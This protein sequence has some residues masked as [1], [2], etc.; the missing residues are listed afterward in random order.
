MVN[1]QSRFSA[2]FHRSCQ[3]FLVSVST[4]TVSGGF[5]L[6]SFNFSNPAPP[7]LLTSVAATVPL[8]LEVVQD[9][10]LGKDRGDGVFLGGRTASGFQALAAVGVAGQQ[11]DA[12][13]RGGQV[14]VAIELPLQPTFVLYTMT[15]LLTLGG[16]FASLAAWAGVFGSFIILKTGYK[17]ALEF[18]EAARKHWLLRALFC[19]KRPQGIAKSEGEAAGGAAAG[20][21]GS[22]LEQPQGGQGAAAAAAAA[23]RH[24]TNPLALA[25]PQQGA[26]AAAAAGEA[27][28]GAGEPPASGPPGSMAARAALPAWAFVVADSLAE[29]EA[30]AAKAAVNS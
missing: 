26:A 3:S 4:A 1:D 16:L 28:P 6:S 7:Q 11:G 21:A 22:A 8:F 24:S 12:D 15:P 19:L 18:P 2:T 29:E 27:G 23:T 30:T 17:D 9:Q 13:D 5:T 25:A 14:T 10:A 20:Q